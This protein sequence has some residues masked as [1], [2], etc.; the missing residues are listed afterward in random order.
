VHLLEGEP[1]TYDVP[2]A[3]NSLL[4]MIPPC[5]ERY[6]HSIPTQKSADVFRPTYDADQTFIPPDKR[7]S[8]T[9]RIAITF[10]FYR[11]DFA[12]SGSKEKRGG[13][14]REGTPRCACQLPWSVKRLPGPPGLTADPAAGQSVD[15]AAC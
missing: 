7:K 12:P 10:R 9:S 5:Q 3:H 11:P 4:C 6:Q 13:R 8:Y 15:F 1:R 2:L 14:R